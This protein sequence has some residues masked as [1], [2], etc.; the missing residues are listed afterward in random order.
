MNQ[1]PRTA[2]RE[3]AGAR[4]PPWCTPTPAPL[5]ENVLDLS[6]G[7]RPAAPEYLEDLPFSVA[8]PRLVSHRHSQAPYLAT[9]ATST[10][11]SRQATT[12]CRRTQEEI[13]RAMGKYF[14]LAV[15]VS[16]GS[17][18]AAGPPIPRPRRE[19]RTNGEEARSAS[20]PIGWPRLP[21][22]LRPGRGRSSSGRG[23]E[24]RVCG[25]PSDCQCG[26]E[27]T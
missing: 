16:A 14:R 22:P 26:D 13:R 5:L 25:Q 7:G 12:R 17:L 2:W 11:C 8:Q 23:P 6:D 15:K 9:R 27:I 3:A 4:W 20:W 21:G 24:V 19:G 10:N 1:T 18:V